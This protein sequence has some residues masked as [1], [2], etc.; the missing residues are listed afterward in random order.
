MT[1]A[2]KIVE[3]YKVLYKSYGPQGWWPFLDHEGT[4]SLKVG[5]TQGY[6][7]LDYSFPRNE[8]EVFEVCLGSILTQNTSFNSVVKSLRNLKNKNA[9]TPEAIHEM[10][11]DE[12]KLC[13]KPSGYHN[14]KSRYILEFITFFN[15][16]KG[17]V[18]SRDR[19]LE[20]LGIGEETADS[21]L[22][23][24]YK[25]LEFKV[26]AYTRRI[27]LSLG[28]IDEKAKYDEIKQLMQEALS[29]SITQ[30]DE[31]L[32]VY[33]EYHALIVN[34]AKLFYSKKPYGRN[35]FLHEMF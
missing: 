21:M 22:L 20:V 25:Q 7:I 30:K 2:D 6:H 19:L 17:E 29:A 10:D 32:I 3:I 12:L 14:Q 8:L 11:I 28:L 5:N 33:Q 34:H 26:D 27:L 4:N 18:P 13:I 16:L 9:L 35:C 15:A 24:G 31:R 1:K 23:F